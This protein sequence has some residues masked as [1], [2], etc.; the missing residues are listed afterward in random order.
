MVRTST[1]EMTQEELASEVE[2]LR[3]TLD[4]VGIS[5]TAEDILHAD[6]EQ[7][8]AWLAEVLATK[9]QQRSGFRQR[10]LE[11]RPDLRVFR[12]RPAWQRGLIRLVWRIL[13]VFGIHGWAPRREREVRERTKVT[14]GGSTPP[15]GK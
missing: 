4:R 6:R 10:L 12:N 9:A 14:T 13:G 7:V 2:I 15:D 5:P 1:H 3:A 8:P 11:V